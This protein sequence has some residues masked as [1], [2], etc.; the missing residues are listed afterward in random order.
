MITNRASENNFNG[1]TYAPGV[2]IV[3]LSRSLAWTSSVHTCWWS[4]FHDWS[5]FGS[6][7]STYSIQ[8]NTQ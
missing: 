7:F 1:F 6:T 2:S 8:A 3:G 5:D 4:D